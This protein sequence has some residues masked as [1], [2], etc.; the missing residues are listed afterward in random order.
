MCLIPFSRQIRSKST[1]PVPGP[2]RPVKT[3]PLSVRIA[4]GTPWRR[5][6]NANASHVGRAVARG[7]ISAEMQNLEWSSTPETILASE[8]STRRTPPTMSICHSSIDRD[9]SQRL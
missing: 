6:A 7:T 5:I 8:P 4:L 1:S 9:R 3:F 2:N